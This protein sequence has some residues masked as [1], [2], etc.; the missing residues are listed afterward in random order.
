ME[1]KAIPF[2]KIQPG[3]NV[4]NGRAGQIQ[5][6]DTEGNIFLSTINKNNEEQSDLSVNKA[7]SSISL[8]SS[9]SSSIDYNPKYPSNNF[10]TINL[11]NASPKDITTIVPSERKNIELGGAL[12]IPYTSSVTAL[13]SITNKPISEKEIDLLFLPAIEPDLV[14]LYDKDIEGVELGLITYITPEEIFNENGSIESLTNNQGNNYSTYKDNNPFNI[15]HTKTRWIG[16]TGFKVASNSGLRFCVFDE[17]YYGIRAGMIN[18][19]GYFTKYNRNTIEKII[20]AYAPGGSKGQSVKNTNTYI[21]NLTNFLQENWK[22]NVTSKTKLTFNGKNETNKDNIKMFKTLVKGIIKIEG[23][24]NY[25]PELIEI[26]NNF[27]LNN[28]N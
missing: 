22:P 4:I 10:N 8:L 1:E 20:N 28:L 9:I 18:L 13:N 27:P 2:R 24:K 5:V 15:I 26:V 7:I 12:D 17:L 6:F 25:T 21:K 3:Y 11:Q 19:S 16:K 14:N 23:N